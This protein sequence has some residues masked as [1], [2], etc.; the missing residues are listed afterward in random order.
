[1]VDRPEKGQEHQRL[2][3]RHVVGVYLLARSLTIG[4]GADHV[5]IR[6]HCVEPGTLQLLSHVFEERRIIADVGVV[7]HHAESHG[8]GT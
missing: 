8:C 5:V 6:Q 1:M 7:E 3:A 4:V 2:V